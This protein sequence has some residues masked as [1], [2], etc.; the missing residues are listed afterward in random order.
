VISPKQKPLPD[1]TQQQQQQQ[2]RMMYL[3][4]AG[5]EL[6]VPASERTQT[7]VLGCA[8]AGKGNKASYPKKK[9]TVF[10]SNAAKT[11]DHKTYFISL[12]KNCI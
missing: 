12:R 6:A 7:H 1:N 3:P 5:F 2:Q 10:L 4:Q 9:N 11:S 8:D